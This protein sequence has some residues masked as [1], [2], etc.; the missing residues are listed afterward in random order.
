MI[1]RRTKADHQAIARRIERIYGTTPIEAASRVPN[2]VPYDFAIF[3]GSRW[4]DD[5]SVAGEDDPGF[6]HTGHVLSEETGGADAT[7]PVQ[8]VIWNHDGNGDVLDSGEIVLLI[9]MNLPEFAESFAWKDEETYGKR[10]MA[11]KLPVKSSGGSSYVSVVKECL[12]TNKV[13][14]YVTGDS[15]ATV[16]VFV[17]VGHLFRAGDL[18]LRTELATPYA[19]CQWAGMPFPN[20]DLRVPGT[21]SYTGVGLTNWAGAQDDPDGE[22]CGD[23]VE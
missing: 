22:F 17:G 14:A 21:G 1:F 9:P 13:K 16:D 15:G 4:Q 2:I 20:W 23:P 18:V 7:D 19:S 3:D 12:S 5:G 6:V 8:W 11:A 10:F